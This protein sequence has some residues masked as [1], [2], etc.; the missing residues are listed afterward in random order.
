[1][2]FERELEAPGARAGG[3]SVDELVQEAALK[4]ARLEERL[5]A[6]APDELCMAGSRP[7]LDEYEEKLRER[8]S[9]IVPDFSPEEAIAARRRLAA[10]STI[11]VP[12]FDPSQI[13]E[14]TAGRDRDDDI[15]IHTALMSRAEFVV[16]DD[17]HISVD[18][19][20]ATQYEDPHSGARVEAL[21]FDRFVEQH[22]DRHPFDLTSVDGGLLELAHEIL[23]T[24]GP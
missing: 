15:V 14:H 5:P 1:M 23:G 7:L 9:R 12:D 10:A 17:K 20:G 22:V 24:S 16:S 19:E 18:R 11:V 8:G 4:K 3:R 13:P 6:L 21:T 2:A